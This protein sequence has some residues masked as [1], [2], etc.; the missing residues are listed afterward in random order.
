MGNAPRHNPS[1]TWIVPVAGA[2]VLSLAFVAPGMPGIVLLLVAGLFGNVIAA[3]HH[4]EV[5]AHKVGNHSARSCL[6]WR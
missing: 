1:W 4:A 6:R 2:M 5:I 3:V